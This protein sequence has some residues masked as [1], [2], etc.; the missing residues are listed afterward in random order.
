MNAVWKEQVVERP[1][2]YLDW[3]F[4]TRRVQRDGLFCSVHVRV[5]PAE[6]GGYLASLY[7]LS[8]AVARG[9]QDDDGVT[10]TL[11]IRM[12]DD[13]FEHL[14]D[15]IKRIEDNGGVV[16]DKVEVQFFIYRLESLIYRAGDFRN[17]EFYEILFA[18]PVIDGLQFHE[19]GAKRS[20]TRFP[21]RL[22]T[23]E[24]V[25][26]GIID[27]GIA[28]AHERFRS[29]HDVSRV[30][31][32][33]LQEQEQPRKTDRGVA[34]GQRLNNDQINDL[35]KSC[36]SDG[37]IYR[38]VGLTD[39]GRNEYNPLASRATH[40]THVLDLA[41]GF[42]SGHQTRP[43]LAVQLPS[44]ATIDTSGVTMGSYVVQAVRAVMLWA[45]KLGD[46]KTPAPLVI[47]FS[48]GLLAGPKDGTQY[49]ERALA[50][51]IHYRDRNIAHTRLVVP[52]GNS[53]RARAA[54]RMQLEPHVD[55]DV[56]WKVSPDDETANFIE[57][58]LDGK[59]GSYSPVEVTLTP[60]QRSAG[61]AIRPETG[62][63]Y[64]L[65]A[66]DRP[67]AGLYYHVFENGETTRERIMLAINPTV[68]NEQ[69]R[70]LAP[71]GSW[72]VSIKNKMKYAIEAHIYIQRDDT[73]FGYPRRG[74]QSRLD[75]KDAYTRDTDTGD[76]REPAEGCPITHQETLSSIATSSP[77]PPDHT[78]VV[79]GAEASENYPPADY[80]ASGPTI[81]RKGPDCSAI[82]DDGDAHRG[83][84]A[85]GTLSGT[86]VAMNGT[87]VAA[88]QIVRKVAND[89]EAMS[90]STDATTRARGGPE[91]PVVAAS[92]PGTIQVPEP[93]QARLGE[94]LLLPEDN[95]E[96]LKRRYPANP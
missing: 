41:S 43:I 17:P 77:I 92:G 64:A 60:P 51:L 28:F 23:D 24:T 73:P 7:Q 71:S 38:R 39:F 70:D 85:A 52:A 4:R 81:L 88:P 27:D 40:G 26:I 2:P 1:D 69:S 42:S 80:T 67:I 22:I 65:M 91:A 15:T 59:A 50:D 94:F 31:A 32:I 87:S 35:L 6:Q 3:E 10:D 56:D 86:K 8:A 34:F 74:R 90:T 33:W 30:Q 83:V 54:A 46:K 36:N 75:R 45:D 5:V 96:T 49:L 19:N 62:V 29:S 84:L 61:H 47:N 12:S 25:A 13:E 37:E 14:Q 68:R 55:Q 21:P 95:A 44:V 66:G 20:P 53:Y 57:I 89:L 11:T 82:A 63:M 78:I 79:G 9:W 18:G 93:N 16:K 76:Y 48:Y 72:N 58:W